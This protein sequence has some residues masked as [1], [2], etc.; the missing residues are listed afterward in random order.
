MAAAV[1]GAQLKNLD[2][3][4]IESQLFDFTLP[5][6]NVFSATPGTTEAISDGK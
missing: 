4:R 6:N 1:D 2:N 5:E 3:Y